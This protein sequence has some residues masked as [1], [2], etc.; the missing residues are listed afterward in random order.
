[1]I[2]HAPI[3]SLSKTVHSFPSKASNAIDPYV[4]AH[5]EWLVNC[6]GIP[7]E[8]TSPGDHEAASCPSTN[9]RHEGWNSNPRPWHRGSPAQCVHITKPVVVLSSHSASADEL[10]EDRVALLCNGD[11]AGDVFV[12]NIVYFLFDVFVLIFRSSNLLIYPF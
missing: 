5:L 1:M 2:I 3:A 9:R 10:L 4:I 6:S 12:P 7:I 8:A 11:S